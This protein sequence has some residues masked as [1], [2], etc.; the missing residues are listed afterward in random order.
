M[1]IEERFTKLMSKPSVDSIQKFNED[2]VAVKMLQTKLKLNKPIY[3]GMVILD[4]AKKIK[5]LLLQHF[6]SKVRGQSQ[7][8]LYR[9]R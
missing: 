7:F 6:E 3:A 2:L 4:L 1:H 9:Y 5:K 8:T